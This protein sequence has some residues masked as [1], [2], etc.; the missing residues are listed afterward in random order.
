LRKWFFSLRK[1]T[2]SAKLNKIISS[3]FAQ[4]LAAAV[5]VG[6]PAEEAKRDL[7]LGWSVDELAR[8]GVK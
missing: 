8:V 1:A 4:R 2:K 6:I 7:L 3:R 5:A